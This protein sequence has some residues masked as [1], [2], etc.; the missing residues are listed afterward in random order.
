[1]SDRAILRSYLDFKPIYSEMMALK[2]E[3][4]NS[5]INNERGLNPK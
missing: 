1:M 5:D 3:W 2:R 4:R